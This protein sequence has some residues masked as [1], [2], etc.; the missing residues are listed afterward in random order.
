MSG[1]AELTRHALALDAVGLADALRA[2]DDGERAEVRDWLLRD[3]NFFEQVRLAEPGLEDM[4]RYGSAPWMHVMC[5]VSVCPPT[6]AA[7]SVR[8]GDIWDHMTPVARELT[9]VLLAERPRAWAETFVTATAR[10]RLS[11]GEGRRAGGC[12][13]WLVERGLADH[14]LPCPDGMAFLEYH[15]RDEWRAPVDAARLRRDRLMPALLYLMIERGCASNATALHQAVPELVEDRTVDRSRLISACL[16][17]LTVETRA[18]SQRIVAKVLTALDLQPEEIPGGLAF[19]TGVMATRDGSVCAVLL[20]RALALV[21]DAVGLAELTRVVAGRKERKQ[22]QDL[23]RALR[24]PAMAATV[25]SDGVVA[26]LHVLAAGQED[27]AL[28]TR[29]EAALAALGATASRTSAHATRLGLWDLTLDPGPE[30]IWPDYLLRDETFRWAEQLD[31]RSHDELAGSWDFTVHTFVRDLA[32]RGPAEVV[33]VCRQLRIDGNLALSALVRMVEP[34]ILAGGLQVS[35]PAALEVADDVASS[36]RVLPG[37]PQLLRLL[38]RYAAEVPAGWHLPPHLAR[39]VSSPGSTRSQLEARALAS[40]LALV[41]EGSE[42]AAARPAPATSSRGL[43]DARPRTPVLARLLDLDFASWPRLR[44]DELPYRLALGNGIAHHSS[45]MRQSAPV[46]D[47]E[48]LR[49]LALE[50]QFCDVE[51]VRRRVAAA[52]RLPGSDRGPTSEAIRLWQTGDLRIETYWEVVSANRL[53]GPS[54]DHVVFAWTCEQLVRL[55]W[56]PGLLSGPSRTDGSVSL[57]HL[58]ATVASF[59]G[60]TT[61]GPLD[62]LLAMTRVRVDGTAEDRDALATLERAQLWT[63]PSVTQNAPFD[64]LPHLRARL[65]EG[66]PAVE[67]ALGQGLFGSVTAEDLSPQLAHQDIVRRLY[68]LDR[69]LPP[70][71]QVWDT[72]F[73]GRI[74]LEDGRLPSSVWPGLFDR[75]FGD[76]HESQR[77]SGLR[78]IAGL[79]IYGEVLDAS[80]TLP[81]AV[82]RFTQGRLPLTRFVDG[83][84]WIFERGGL[85]QLWPLGLGVAAAAVQASPKPNGLPFLLSSLATYAVEVPIDRIN[86]PPEIVAFAESPGRTKSHLAARE[87]VDATRACERGGS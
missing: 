15:L 18:S 25:G 41:R 86:L 70:L 44:D 47:E 37:L 71:D 31:R 57:P 51:D 16:Q 27:A 49:Q 24:D 45:F 9:A 8:W 23:L 38:T 53:A 14:D 34:A 54:L 39:L 50:A 1:V 68:P 11:A 35:W 59:A 6:E 30:R 7:R 13:A 64:V 4:Q 61:V 60:V 19:L 58:A 21:D 12:L 3:K 56:H 17:S 81:L 69:A 74:V 20:P 67:R 48:L 28:T 10:T 65:A 55:S 85:R 33:A 2:L 26:A 43:W 46:R 77:E 22:K 80:V 32:S 79:A 40:A 78:H 75:A 62:L 42:D 63:D 87:L 52:P 83:L 36:G 76:T 72:A 5:L 29:V 73:A 84:L 66:Y 82:D